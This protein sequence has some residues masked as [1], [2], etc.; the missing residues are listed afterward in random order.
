MKRIFLA[1]LQSLLIFF[2]AMGLVF[3][4]VALVVGYN[5]FKYKFGDKADYCICET[6]SC[7]PAE[8]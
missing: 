3:F 1:L 4:L 5:H 2:C 7:E 8:E 6:C